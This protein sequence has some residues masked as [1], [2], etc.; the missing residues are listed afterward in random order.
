[1]IKTLKKLI[2]SVSAGLLFLT[3]GTVMPVCGATV[4]VTLTIR[5]SHNVPPAR[6]TNLTS[7]KADYVAGGAEGKINLFWTAPETKLDTLVKDYYIRWGTQSVTAD[8]SGDTTAWWNQAGGINLYNWMNNPGDT[9]NHIAE[10]LTPSVTY[11][12]AIK[13]RDKFGN[14]SDIDLKTF[15]LEQPF[16]IASVDDIKPSAITNLIAAKGVSRGK[17]NLS[18]TAPGDDGLHGTAAKY[19]IR[20]A[21]FSIAS[22]G[23]DTNIWWNLSNNIT[24][25]SP[26]PMPSIQGSNESLPITGLMSGTTYYFAIKSADERDNI[27]EINT[28]FAIAP[29]GCPGA[30]ISLVAATGTR[31]RE[32]D[33]QWIAP[34][35]IEY[36]G[37]TLR[38]YFIRYATFS[39][40]DVGNST[41]AWWNSAKNLSEKSPIP[42]PSDPGSNENLTITGLVR[43]ATYYFAIKSEDN[44]GN[45]SDIDISIQS[46]NQATAFAQKDTIL[47]IAV[48]DLFAATGANEG[49]ILLSWTAPDDGFPADGVYPDKVKK[50]F[51]KFSTTAPDN[52]TLWWNNAKDISEKSPVP[53]PSEP[54][55]SE[56]MTV[57]GLIGN[58]L[59]YFAIKSEDDWGN[60]SLI[61]NIPGAAAAEY[62]A[63]PFPPSGVR[64]NEI[65]SDGTV[66]LSFSSV[67]INTDRSKYVKRGI[68]RIYRK[69]IGA[70]NW[71]I[72]ATI[73][74]L[75]HM[76][77]FIYEDTDASTLKGVKL[78]RIT[79]VDIFGNESKPSMILDTSEYLNVIAQHYD[80]KAKLQIPYTVNS[81][82]YAEENN[83]GEDLIIDV[84]R[85]PSEDANILNKFH[86][87][88]ISA[89][90]GK[91][92]NSVVFEEA[93][94]R[95]SIYFDVSGCKI[96]GSPRAVSA[97][98]AEKQLSLYWFNGLEWVKLGGEVD[99]FKNRVSINVKSLGSYA[100]RLSYRGDSFE[101]IS[102]HPDKIF[103]PNNDGWLDFFEIKYDNP[104][105]ASVRGKIY[106]LNGVWIADMVRGTTEG[107]AS[108]SLK[109]DGTNF[110]GK[111][112]SG[113]V[114]IYQ[115]E[116]T[117]EENKVINGTVVIAR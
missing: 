8:F 15:N 36:G 11:Y 76:D 73:E 91:T 54:G 28:A 111:R 20:Y 25:K 116:V 110:D 109:W 62:S 102:I 32:I 41:Q 114:Y 57:T 33:L 12:F 51:I 9:M 18:W 49:T 87:K 7:L 31:E 99:I 60:I 100:L 37:G 112:M 19:F 80:K 4:D 45:L 63:I 64:I 23:G 40:T 61:S 3:A 14:L 84:V 35:T 93:L 5:P 39:V 52:T 16:A 65:K 101:I 117:G 2:F 98:E 108:G 105:R 43:G 90:T 10:N 69:I 56:N 53:A 58:K 38:T 24:E 115:I 78:Y 66:V 82:L 94:V 70:A 86:F 6:I 81:I 22:V 27:S 44:Y 97:W 55:V 26:I 68:Y 106:D 67:K 89:A 88:A 104:K 92:I 77:K 17:I 29:R 95:L 96:S 48:T 42:T 79:A 83:I 107:F 74:D 30:V 85:L 75:S 13:A 71:E 50:Y 1:M 46:S 113:G 103:T 59:Y 34:G 72:I 47:P 21:T